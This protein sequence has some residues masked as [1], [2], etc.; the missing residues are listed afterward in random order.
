MTT[1]RSDSRSDAAVEAA[2]QR[3][4]ARCT[5]ADGQSPF[6]EA[7]LLEQTAVECFELDGALVGAAMI[8][9]AD[10]EFAVDPGHRRRGIGR[11]ILSAIAAPGRAVWAHGDHPGALALAR[12]FGMHRER[13]LLQLRARLDDPTASAVAATPEGVTI[14]GFREGLDEDDWV[15]LNA[16]VFA[17]HPEQG[18]ITRQ[19]LAPRLAENGSGDFLVA[20][21]ETGAMVGYCWLKL[22]EGL[23]EIYVLGVDPGFAGRGLGRALLAAGLERLRGHGIRDSSLYVE[24]DNA[25]ALRLYRGF[26]YR[27]H[28]I[29]VL[30]RMPDRVASR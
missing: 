11:E 15:A 27:D 29:D 20:R 4:I 26:G 10:A 7:S 28:T 24:A 9:S 17:S 2:L 1:R 16:R 21:D 30:Y 14:G 18:R 12:E 23:G 22:A 25:P 13:V 6:N 8:G 19:T 3:L 5:E